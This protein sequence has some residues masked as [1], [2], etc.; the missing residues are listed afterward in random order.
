MSAG[1]KNKTN[2]SDF[3]SDFDKLTDKM[4][5][6]SSTA[7]GPTFWVSTGNYVINKIISG[8]YNG[9]IGQGRMAMLAGPS[10]A[11]K[12]FLVGNIIKSAQDD[13]CGVVVIDSE[14][15]M[16]DNFLYAIG[17]NPDDADYVYRGVVTF[18][19]C[20]K[21]ISAFLKTY[22][23]NKETKKFLIVIDSLDGLI[24][25]SAEANY[26]KGELK[27]DQGQK[28]KQ[29]K[30]ML[31]P[32]VQDIKDLNIAFLCTKQVYQ[33]QEQSDKYHQST[34]WK[35]TESV[36]YPFS[37]IALITR[38]MIKTDQQNLDGT[39]KYDGID[40]RVFGLKTRFTKP[41]QQAT[42]EVPYDEGMDPYTGTLDV[43]VSLG[44]VSKAGSWYTFND[45]KFQSK[46]YD[47][48]KERVL[49]E[50][51]VK[52]SQIVNVQETDAE[53]Y[54]ELNDLDPKEQQEIKEE[55]ARKKLA[56][57]SQSAE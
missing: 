23:A 52:E 44:V 18:V 40:L 56:K 1:K 11:G 10:S 22:R 5:G 32:F 57:K 54:L 50:L 19:Q 43:A 21:I 7:T 53:L 49:A 17:A 37:Q 30:A 42:I 28:A 34:A 36:K 24:T 47:K 26:E 3:L 16:D 33:S 35:L 9:G 12:S 6:V 14:N 41:F 4:E 39:K 15:A 2:R 25:D 51:I 48:Y 20:T 45:E 55:V 8:K 31:A 29:I 27:G 13:G 38:L 46:N